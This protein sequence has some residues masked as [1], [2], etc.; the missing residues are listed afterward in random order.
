MDHKGSNTSSIKRIEDFFALP[1]LPDSWFWHKESL[2]EM[3]DH[4]QGIRDDITI[5]AQAHP[6]S[7]I[8]PALFFSIQDAQDRLRFMRASGLSSD[9]EQQALIEK[10][11]RNHLEKLNGTLKR[12]TQTL[13]RDFILQ[14]V[15]EERAIKNNQSYNFIITECRAFLDGITTQDAFVAHLRRGILQPEPIIDIIKR[16]LHR[17]LPTEPPKSEINWTLDTGLL[18]AG[19]GHVSPHETQTKIVVPEPLITRK[20]H[21]YMRVGISD[22]SRGDMTATIIIPPWHFSE[23]L[24]ARLIDLARSKG[25]VVEI[26]WKKEAI[27][28]DVETSAMSY[29]KMINFVCD[30]LKEIYATRKKSGVPFIRVIACSAGVP[31]AAGALK[32]LDDEGRNQEVF[33][34]ITDVT[35][36]G[37]ADL[38]ADCYRYGARTKSIGKVAERNGWDIHRLREKFSHMAP[39]ACLPALEKIRGQATWITSFSDIHFPLQNQKNVMDAI[40]KRGSAKIKAVNIPKIGHVGIS[41][42]Y[43]VLGAGITDDKSLSGLVGKLVTKRLLKM[44]DKLIT[45]IDLHNLP[46]GVS[47]WLLSRFEKLSDMLSGGL[48][49]VPE[50]WWDSAMASAK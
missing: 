29:H 39:V 50:E 20:D 8:D 27:S 9:R 18:L 6:A 25:P 3:Q 37:M 30:S 5:Y 10:F 16:I 32:K 2:K 17:H 36:I 22:P 19:F 21:P 48:D 38:F 24:H 23:K 35:F 26:I 28:A 43:Y 14:E 12:L 1:P 34:V 11:K 49:D 40:E 31:I 4:L 45:Q 46:P 47:K 33:D 13:R 41:A 7:G 44:E 15:M 42:V